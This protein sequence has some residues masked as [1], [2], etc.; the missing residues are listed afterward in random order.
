MKVGTSANWP[1]DLNTLHLV[2]SDQ[3]GAEKKRPNNERAAL[4]WT[5]S[6]LITKFNGNL[7][8]IHLKGTVQTQ[9]L[10]AS[11][12]GHR[13]LARNTSELI[14]DSFEGIKLSCLS[15]P[16]EPLLYVSARAVW[17]CI[18]AKGIVRKSIQLCRET[19]AHTFGEVSFV[20]IAPLTS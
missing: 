17:C 10:V 14:E 9:M 13:K 5:D 11:G 1:K 3:A 19:H 4:L 16:A 12:T 15:Q 6:C 7:S 2:G 8:I 18:A 20:S